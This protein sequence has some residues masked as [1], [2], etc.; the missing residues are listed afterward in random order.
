M[1]RPR[2]AAAALRRQQ[3]CDACT[4]PGPSP[5]RLSSADGRTAGWGETGHV[6]RRGLGA[7]DFS[8]ELIYYINKLPATDNLIPVEYKHLSN[9]HTVDYSTATTATS[10][11]LWLLTCVDL[12]HASSLQ[13]ET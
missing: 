10:L 3:R 12:I 1:A 4:P 2:W 13:V 9:T 7:A 11:L 5:P 6:C 8:A